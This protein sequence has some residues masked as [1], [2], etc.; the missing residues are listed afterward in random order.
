[1]RVENFQGNRERLLHF[2]HGLKLNFGGIDDQHEPAEFVFFP[3][4]PDPE[5]FSQKLSELG[6]ISGEPSF[7]LN[8]I[9]IDV[10]RVQE[11]VDAIR[12]GLDG[13]DRSVDLVY[14]PHAT[15]EQLYDHLDSGFHILHFVGHGNEIGCLLFEDENSKGCARYISPGELADMV[16]D[17]VAVFINSA[18]HGERSIELLKDGKGASPMSLIY[19]QGEFPIPTRAM[20]LFS[21]GFYRA[22]LSGK[23]T[24]QAF[25]QGVHKIRRDDIVGEIAWQDG[26][27][28]DGGPSPYKR[29]KLHSQQTICFSDV[30]NGDLQIRDTSPALAPHVKTV[31]DRDRIIGREENLIRLLEE[32][33]PPL[34][35]IKATKSRLINLHGEGGIGKT[36]LA[37]A[38]CDLAAEYH[39]FPGGIF[40]I[41]CSRTN[42]T[43]RLALDI[44]NA[45]GIAEGMEIPDPIAFLPQFLQQRNKEKG[46]TLLLLDNIEQLFSPDSEAL[47][48]HPGSLLKAMLSSSAQL[49]ILTT[50]RTKVPLGGYETNF[51]VDPLAGDQAWSLFLFFISDPE[52]KQDVLSLPNEEKL[53][54]VK[55]FDL[56]GGH[57]L[58]L[59][60]AAQR[61]MHSPEPIAAQIRQAQ[62]QLLQLLEAPEL[63]ALPERQRS[64]RASLDIS[65]RCLS[66]E[67]QDVFCK[68]SFFPGGLFRYVATLD[69][70]LGDNWREL[71]QQACDM[72]LYRFERDQQRYWMLSPIREY[73]EQQLQAA[74][75]EAFYSKALQFWAKFVLWSDFLLNP[76]QDPEAMKQLDLPQA[77]EQLRQK[78]SELHRNAFNA[79]MAEED[80][81]LHAFDWGLEH[82]FDHAEQIATGLIDYFGLRDR[83]QTRAWLA[84]K[85]IANSQT[86]EI[87]G[88]W[89]NNLSVSLSKIGD[90]DGARQRTE[91]ALEIYQNLADQ[92]PEAFL[93]YVAGTLNNLGNILSELGDRHGALKRTEEALAI[94]QQ[95]VEQHPEAFLPYVATTLNN[96]GQF[97]A[98]L[99]DR[100]GARQR[101]EQ[102]LAIYQQ[103][104]DQHP[105]AFLPDLA[106]TLNNLGTILSELGDRDGARQRTEEALAIYQNLAEQHP[107]AF[108]PDLAMTLNNLG[109]FM[110]ELGDRDGA[111]Q[112]TEQALA[113]YQNLADQHPEAFLPDLAM[114]LNNLGNILSELGDRDGALQRTQQALAIYQ[115]L[116]D[117]H[118]EA[119]IDKLTIVL[120]NVCNRY[121]DLEQFDQAA[122]HLHQL[123][124]ASYFLAAVQ[125]DLAV[126]IHAVFEISQKLTRIGKAEQALPHIEQAEELLK[127]FADQ[128][129]DAAQD[130]ARL[131]A[132]KTE[133]SEQLQ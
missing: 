109:Q 86:D 59:F 119:F 62:K 127:P 27:G 83:R 74:D 1:M 29:L 66:P 22:L 49:H 21:Q 46:R 67:A 93:P 82:D 51:I 54:L 94:Y 123:A 124:Q 36:R 115:N 32:L 63:R 79:L 120:R 103:L 15:R 2:F 65:F 26:S 68:S 73:A 100:D 122:E 3:P 39:L 61:F 77:P 52:I 30:Q 58:S 105:E 19:T 81:I 108:L 118:P 14:L 8:P 40:E 75:K 71:I 117:Q 133:I 99:G 101:T 60:L 50:S 107:E 131:L 16:G 104:A 114:T 125:K 42:D 34:P 80:N 33:S 56:L 121:M 47:T 9:P 128:N 48:P 44:L 112:R 12:Q 11:E 96:L 126:F 113:I 91:E 72:G 17:K 5:F 92:H 20:Q 130:L 85:V 25:Q 98:E 84:A 23:S 111:R 37:Q 55:L 13:I 110:A 6:F 24:D 69:P 89:L 70:L 57:P 102:A 7:R 88:K 35:G 43:K 64:L 10:L 41:D 4:F 53:G 78:L 132:I 129:Q 116:A 97:M 90:R 87:K 31:R 106:M 38:A 28:D 76:A 95:L 18:C 45:L